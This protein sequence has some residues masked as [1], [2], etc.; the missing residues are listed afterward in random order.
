MKNSGK[1]KAKRNKLRSE[2][3]AILRRVD[4][5]P[6]LDPR[7]PDEIVGYD[8]NGIPCTNTSP[9]SSAASA[10]DAGDPTEGPDIEEWRKTFGREISPAVK[11]FL[12][13]RHREWELGMEPHLKARSKTRPERQ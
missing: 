11:D 7:T 5:M 9:S 6:D 12:Q 2:L 10:H 1:K 13:Y 4:R 3:D 8:E